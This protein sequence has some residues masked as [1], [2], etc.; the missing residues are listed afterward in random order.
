MKPTFGGIALLVLAAICHTPCAGRGNDPESEPPAIELKTSR[1]EPARPWQDSTRYTVRASQSTDWS[2]S[3][4]VEFPQTPKTLRMSDWSSF[5]HQEGWSALVRDAILVR[6]GSTV[7]LQHAAG[8]EWHHGEPESQSRLVVRYEIDLPSAF[9]AYQTLPKTTAPWTDGDSLV[10]PGFSMF[11]YADN[12]KSFQVNFE[13]PAGWHVDAG[14]RRLKNSTSFAGS[15]VEELHKNTCVVGDHQT[16]DVDAGGFHVKAVALGRHREGIALLKSVIESHAQ[17]FQSLFNYPN[18]DS[19]LIVL[20]D[21][22]WVTG[23]S[24]GSSYLHSTASPINMYILGESIRGRIRSRIDSRF[25]RSGRTHGSYATRRPSEY[26]I[27]TLQALPQ[28]AGS[29]T[30]SDRPVA[31][32][33]HQPTPPML[34]PGFGTPNTMLTMPLNTH[35]PSFLRLRRR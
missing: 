19:Y 27:S 21:D 9:A 18:Q 26:T 22:P 23:E 3:V 11:M 10:I 24:F 33:F 15:S 35:S 34:S 14:W 30:S 31:L 16:L 5:A 25:L 13:L 32:M 29:A 20:I 28:P 17:R 6:D 2:L 12:Q 8:N 4:T 7:P 1:A